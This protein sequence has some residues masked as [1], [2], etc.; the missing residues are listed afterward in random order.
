M[1]FSKSTTH[2]HAHSHAHTHSI[3][4]YKYSHSQSLKSLITKMVR[5][6]NSCGFNN[7]YLFVVKMS[8]KNE[9]TINLKNKN[10]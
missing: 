7:F 1:N 9:T 10:I 8:N 2:T 6:L 3:Q 4:A 5:K